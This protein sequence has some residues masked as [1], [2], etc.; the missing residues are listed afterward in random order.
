MK[1]NRHPIK[2]RPMIRAEDAWFYENEASIE[3]YIQTFGL[4]DGEKTVA[5]RIRR[6]DL[7]DWLKR[8]KK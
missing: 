5:C 2:A 7:E 1:V 8:T 6:A 3:V 4:A